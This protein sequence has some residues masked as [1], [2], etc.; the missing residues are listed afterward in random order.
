MFSQWCP[1]HAAEI[2]LGADAIVGMTATPEGI[3]VRWR[4]TC[5]HTGVWWPR[6]TPPG[7]RYQ[8][9]RVA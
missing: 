8:A 1:R 3:A 2:L 6:R 5:G 7:Y 4:C 9:R